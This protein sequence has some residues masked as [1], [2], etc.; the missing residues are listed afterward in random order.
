MRA[1]NL[2]PADQ[3]SGGVGAVR[4]QSDGAAFIVLGLLAGL[5]ILVFLYGSARH[6][7]S[8]KK[9]EA[10]KLSAQA[11]STEAQA[12][13]LA[14]YTDFTS[15]HDERVKDIEQLVGTR[16]DWSH[17]FH[18]IGRVIPTDV[19]LSSIQGSVGGGAAVSSTPAASTGST[20]SATPAG[21]VP[22]ITITGCTVSQ[23]E[24]A[25]TLARLR[26]IDGVNEVDLQSSS[27]SGSGSSSGSGSGSSGSS[28]SE[29]DPVFTAQITFTPLPTP[30][31]GSGSSGSSTA[32][33]PGSTSAAAT[34]TQPSTT[35]APTTTTQPSTTTTSSPSTT[36]TSSS[37]S[38]TAN[39]KASTSTAASGAD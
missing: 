17:A 31:S 23:S 15:L 30:S 33:A 14:P 29:K 4:G 6:E 35:T 25:V 18:E 7:I 2:I 8:T 34:N 39:P 1:V 5:A 3:R 11:Q 22:V 24:V 12:S 21:S 36:P 32:A 9:A 37:S 13:K 28:C 20:G 19:S 26:L 16:F 27:K 10:A 38:S